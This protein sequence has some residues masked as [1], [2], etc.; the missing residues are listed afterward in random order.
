MTVAE[1]IRELQKLDQ[2]LEVITD[3]STEYSGYSPVSKI[4]RVLFEGLTHGV[5]HK[6]PGK[7]LD[8][9]VSSGRVRQAVYLETEG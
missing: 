5:I 9:L 2:N 7:V 4:S 8:H 1:L 6:D 3:S